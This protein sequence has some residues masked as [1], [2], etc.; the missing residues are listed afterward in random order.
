MDASV[1]VAKEALFFPLCSVPC[2]LV[3]SP[4]GGTV[5]RVRE[6]RVIVVAALLC[7]SGTEKKKKTDRSSSQEQRGFGRQG[8]VTIAESE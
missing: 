6:W 3:F 1:L 7:W 5:T 8:P 2:A 4:S